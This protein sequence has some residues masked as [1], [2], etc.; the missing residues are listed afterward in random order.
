MV[1][2][3]RAR[4]SWIAVAVIAVVAVVA[5][6][7]AT[8]SFVRDREHAAGGAIGGW[9]HIADDHAAGGVL[10]QRFRRSVARD[11]RGDRD[12]RRGDVVDDV[13]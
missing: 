6:I 12:L 11:A 7:V 3:Q 2:S 5:A 1:L 8:Q 4:T 10:M 13:R 9:G